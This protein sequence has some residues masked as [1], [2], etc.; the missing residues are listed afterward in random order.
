MRS[1]FLRHAAKRAAAI[2]FIYFFLA[3]PASRATIRY[4]VSL[5]HPEQHLFHITM[6]IP[7]VSREVIVQLPAWNALY[8]IRD[9][10]SHLREVQAFAENK[11]APVEK[12]D[13]QTWKVFGSG[14][15]TLRY[16]A[17][18]D[19]PGPFNTQLNGEHAFFNPAM[20]LFYIP[21]RREEA[22]QLSVTDAA[23]GWRAA[24][25][26]LVPARDSGSNPQF[27]FDGA[28][29]DSLA[30]APVELSKFDEFLLPGIS[31][32]VRVVIHGE[33]WKKSEVQEQLK[34]ICQYEIKLM[35]GAPYRGYTFIFHIG[36]AA[37]GGVGGMEHADSTAIYVPSDT[38]L[39]NVSAHEFF[40]LW[41][42]KRIRPA[43]LEPVDYTREQYSRALW[44][45]EGVTNTYS[46]Y[47]LVRTGIWKKQEFY[48]DLSG[49]ISEVESRPAEQWQSAEQSSLDAWLEKYALY[50]SSQE[51]ISYYTK[52]QVLGVLLD[53]AIRERTDN[54]RSL[55]DVL[56]EM[57][58]QFARQGKSYRDSL[59]VRLTAEKIA[60]GSFEEF[61]RKY[62]SG[63]EPL[64]YAELFAPAGLEL[65]H[66]ETK[67]TVLGFA[68]Q[69]DANGILSIQSVDAENTA[70]KAKLRSG[71]EI[72]SWD[73]GEPPKKTE[74]WAAQRK[75][76]EIVELRIRREGKEAVVE[77][78]LGEAKE[79]YYQVAE[80]SHVGEK[81]KRIR[82]GMLH[83]TTSPE[84]AKQK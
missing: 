21:A 47:T 79:I 58:T 5:A 3:A 2:S 42:V 39:A 23:D 44:F 73:G 31:P 78:P 71:D 51:S 80:S 75:A 70:A 33:S 28:S 72:L 81:T 30:D 59:D 40:H 57:N 4:E 49:Q 84:E 24:S 50:N 48:D 82:E 8:Q 13:K 67:R 76:G 20:I 34:R 12:L 25:S 16:S 19:E 53:L 52:G 17:F 22:V 32:P 14:T 65:R 18:W 26:S 36:H 15:V 61:F 41:N 27:Y 38:Y 43:S 77:I 56:R 29:Y 37:T 46:S 7:D 54:A 60:G 1:H 9:F 55:D 83:G 62:V 11:T 64:P 74:R 66:V 6:E 68:A 69:R 10:S 63:T 45:S 35:E